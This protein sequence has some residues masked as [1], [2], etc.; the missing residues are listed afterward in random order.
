M[1]G[2]SRRMQLCETLS[3]GDRRF[4]AV[5]RVDEKQFLIGGAGNSVALLTPLATSAT[6]SVLADR[7]TSIALEGSKQ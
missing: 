7:Q 1:G 2:R 3:L 5:V 6:P 4:L